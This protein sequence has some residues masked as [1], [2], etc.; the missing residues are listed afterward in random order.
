MSETKWGATRIA[1]VVSSPEA[2]GLL[3]EIQAGN[4]PRRDYLGLA[5]ALDAKLITSVISP[6]KNVN[7]LSRLCNI[8]TTAWTAFRQ[9]MPSWKFAG[10]FAGV[11]GGRDRILLWSL[12][13]FVVARHAI[14]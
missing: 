2:E 5:E 8:F 9:S 6:S 13:L 10:V 12:P 14:P 3:D 11:N 4:H 7:R 1:I